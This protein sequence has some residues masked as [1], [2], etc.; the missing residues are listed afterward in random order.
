MKICKGYKNEQSCSN[1]RY[2]ITEILL[3]DIHNCSKAHSNNGEVTSW[4]MKA[5]GNYL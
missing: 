1:I 2:D 5:P 4:K 3:I